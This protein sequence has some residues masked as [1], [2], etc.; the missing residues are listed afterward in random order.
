LGRFL[1]DAPPN[2]IRP[3][4]PFDFVDAGAVPCVVAGGVVGGDEGGVI[5]GDAVAGAGADG[6]VGEDGVVGDCDIVSPPL[7]T[8]LTFLDLFIFRRN[9]PPEMV[10]PEHGQLP[11]FI[12]VNCI[13]YA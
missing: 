2:P 5:G 3:Q 8:R 13:L 9:E 7:I 4:I 11:P 12:Y 10:D 6:V 1:R